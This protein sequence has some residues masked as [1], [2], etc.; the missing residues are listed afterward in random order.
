MPEDH[1][2][3]GELLVRL[4]LVTPDQVEGALEH[5][6]RSGE[7]IGQALVSLGHVDRERLQQVLLAALGVEELAVPPRPAPT[8]ESPTGTL[9]ERVVVVD[10]SEIY[11]AMVG[12]ELTERG[13]E[14]VCLHD[15]LVALKEIPGLKPSLVLTDL[16]M[17]GMSGAELCTALKAG[18][19]PQLPVI[20]LTGHEAEAVSGLRSGADDY[21]QKGADLDELV[22][23]MES[24]LRRARQ[25]QH[26]RRLFARYTSDE[27]VEKILTGGE[28]ALSGEK[29]EVTILFVD[30]RSFSALSERHPPEQVLRMLNRVLGR[31]SDVVLAC[32]GR[33]DKF[34]GDGLMAVFGAPVAHEDD[35][36]R[37]MRA[38]MRMM[39]EAG[40][41][42]R[43]A[44]HGGD[45]A[46]WPEEGLQLG[47]GINTGVVV[48]GNLGSERRSEYTCIGDSVNVC[49]RLCELAR[50]GQVLIGPRTRELLGDAAD[51]GPHAMMRLRGRSEPTPV[52]SLRWDPS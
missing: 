10:D 51:V 50:P 5:Q 8:A 27:V 33:V 1:L 24:V 28:V 3:F 48:V 31:L 46:I 17:P 43:G 21:I 35:P 38:A 45:E 9:R 4:G 47:I 37:A 6:R 40:E 20:I 34:L 2:L 39:Q 23:R 49:S 22:A 15:P 19:F 16:Q 25:V 26:V 11:A 32:D 29:R 14:V 18:P 42:R 12:H 7:R 44:P 41:L 13:Y 52:F 36:L 30:I